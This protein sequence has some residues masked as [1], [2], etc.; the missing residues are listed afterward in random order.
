MQGLYIQWTYPAQ[1]GQRVAFGT[2]VVENSTSAP[3]R[4]ISVTVTNNPKGLVVHT[5][6]YPVSKKSIGIKVGWVP[7]RLTPFRIA[8]GSGGW[9]EVIV[10]ERATMAGVFTIQGVLMRYIWKGHTYQAYL[11]DQFTLCTGPEAKQRC[12]KPI[13][14]PPTQWPGG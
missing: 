12:Y 1:V 10:N 11:R 9:A 5:G 4:I 3:F 2:F 8:P 14:P 7:V 6:M 13:P